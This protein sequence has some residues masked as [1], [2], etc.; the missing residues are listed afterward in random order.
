MT[1]QRPGFPYPVFGRFA[2]TLPALCGHYLFEYFKAYGVWGNVRSYQTGCTRT[3]GHWIL[4]TP[5]AAASF[6]PLGSVMAVVRGYGAV[7]CLGILE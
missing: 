5:A 6:P 1:Q 7:F 4:E 3:A 2:Y